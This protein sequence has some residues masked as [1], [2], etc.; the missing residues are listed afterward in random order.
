MTEHSAVLVE[1]AGRIAAAYVAQT[2][3]RAIL[4]AGSA[5]AGT[6]DG[7]SDLDLIVYHDRLPT[8]DDLA[9]ARKLVGTTDARP[10]ASGDAESRIEEFDLLG[11]ECQVGHITVAAWER[12]MAA[13]LVERTPATPPER[14]IIGL[15]GGLALHGEDLIVRWQRRAAIL[16][17]SLA[18]TTVVHYQQV[19]PLWLAPE[20]WKTRDAAIFYHH[21][22]A[23][24]SLNLLGMLA[25]PVQAA[26]PV[27]RHLGSGAPEPRRSP[28]RVVHP[29]PD[30]RR[31]Y[32]GTPGR[33]DGRAGGGAHAHGRYESD[34]PS[35]WPASPA[36]DTGVHP[37]ELTAGA[38]ATRPESG[39]TIRDEHSTASK[40]LP[41]MPSCNSCR[42]SLSQRSSGTPQ[43]N[44]S[45]PLSA[46]SMP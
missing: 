28:G 4:V 23:E 40:S 7:L 24:S 16:P 29:R 15:L 43:R 19:F 14:A 27:R 1:L 41:K 45:L 26:P 35:P 38:Q 5:A 9:A 17:E 6:N 46:S 22:L 31:G 18:H 12:D 44:Q 39:F 3:P 20:R 42:S 37:R 21:A 30:R 34:P 13:V 33:G 10:P 11:I 36:V 8:D 25:I 2:E 32:T